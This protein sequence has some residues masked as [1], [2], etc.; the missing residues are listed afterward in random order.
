[1]KE[2][3]L[4]LFLAKVFAYST[5]RTGRTKTPTQKRKPITI[6]MI[7]II[8]FVSYLTTAALSNALAASAASN[9]LINLPKPPPSLT[10]EKMK[11][12]KKKIKIL[13]KR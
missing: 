13:L 3:H 11:K 12:I 7:F 1:M 10:K 8:L 6:E 5:L 2:S 9:L 4:T